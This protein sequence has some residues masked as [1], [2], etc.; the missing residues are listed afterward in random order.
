MNITVL[1]ALGSFTIA[2]LTALA[3]FI[4]WYAS[5]EKKK[6]GL[7]RDFNHLKNNQA[8]IQQGIDILLRE[9]DRRFDVLE[10]DI[11]EIKTELCL[12]HTH[13]KNHQ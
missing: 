11:L 8:S 7:E 9:T 6:Y 2:L 13:G 4:L 5:S 12:P 10:R 1:A 3:G